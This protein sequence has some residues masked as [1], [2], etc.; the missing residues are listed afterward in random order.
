MEQGLAIGRRHV[1]DASATEHVDHEVDP[2]EHILADGED[3]VREPHGL[4]ALTWG[5]CFDPKLESVDW[6]VRTYSTI[7]EP[8]K[9]K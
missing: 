4:Q 5:V 3:L 1:R 8:C 2:R 9:C 7:S 6:W